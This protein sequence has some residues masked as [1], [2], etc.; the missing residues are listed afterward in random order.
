MLMTEKI[1]VGNNKPIFTDR[2][3]IQ[4]AIDIELREKKKNWIQN[5]SVT[6][7]IYSILLA[8]R[9][10]EFM[11]WKPWIK[12]FNIYKIVS[13]M[14]RHFGLPDYSRYGYIY[15]GQFTRLHKYDQ[16]IDLQLNGLFRLYEYGYVYNA[17]RQVKTRVQSIIIFDLEAQKFLEDFFQNQMDRNEF[18]LF[19]TKEEENHLNGGYYHKERQ[20]EREF[21]AIR[22][23]TMAAHQEYAH[24]LAAS[25]AQ[26][27]NLVYNNG[28]SSN[29]TVTT[30]ISMTMPQDIDDDNYDLSPQ[31]YIYSNIDGGSD[32]TFENS[33]S[34]TGGAELRFNFR[35]RRS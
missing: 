35:R 22:A 1:T 10:R 6:K 2:Q 25:V 18:S 23:R 4:L 30:N 32:A 27:F 26:E 31:T 5:N 13:R 12:T 24:T 8:R 11:D 7:H 34:T 21:H 9:L 33:H 19:S 15:S 29:A 17:W 14:V 20:A 16:N 28:D 3:L